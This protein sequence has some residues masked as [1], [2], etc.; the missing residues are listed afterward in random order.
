MRVAVVTA[1]AFYQAQ[2]KL[3]HDVR[4]DGRH[5]AWAK[6]LRAFKLTV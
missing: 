6:A 1:R 5:R 2:P 3:A 4:K